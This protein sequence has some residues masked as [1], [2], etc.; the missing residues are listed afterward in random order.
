MNVAP[1]ASG[2][3]NIPTDQHVNEPGFE[4]CSP[5]NI[6]D[7]FMLPMGNQ[8]RNSISGWNI[9]DHSHLPPHARPETEF[10]P[11]FVSPHRDVTQNKSHALQTRQPPRCLVDAV[12]SPPI[13]LSS[14]VICIIEHVP[15]IPFS[16][17]SSRALFI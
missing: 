13:P 10:L 14:R 3:V 12:S 8:T 11:N 15:N 6:L 1:P 16:S 5:D 2:V 9:G 17:S 7:L 4:S